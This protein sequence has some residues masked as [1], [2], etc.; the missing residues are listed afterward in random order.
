MKLDIDLTVRFVPDR[1]P[2]FGELMAKLDKIAAFLQ[3]FE[4]MTMSALTDLQDAVTKEDTVIDGAVTLLTGLKAKLDAA[5]TD[6]A[7][8]KALSADIGAKTQA[9]ADAL[10]ANT[11][12]AAPPAPA[13]A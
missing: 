10:V 3:T 6:P 2:R 9:L 4:G 7:A 13:V 8:L 1:D 5:G 11:P 12:A